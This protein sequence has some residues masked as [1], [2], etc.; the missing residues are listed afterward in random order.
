VEPHE[1]GVVV[2]VGPLGQI[3]EDHGNSGFGRRN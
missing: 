2:G 1:D 3:G